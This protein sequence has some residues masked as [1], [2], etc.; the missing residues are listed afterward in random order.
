MLGLRLPGLEFRILCL[1]GS[2]IINSSHHPQ[3]VLLAQFS[4]APVAEIGFSP[5]LT[6]YKIVGLSYRKISGNNRVKNIFFR[7][8]YISVMDIFLTLWSGSLSVTAMLDFSGKANTSINGLS[9]WL[10]LAYMCTK[11]T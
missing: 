8:S 4:L 3:E 9:P 10:S 11:V 2:V 1:E 5:R 7:I 6:A